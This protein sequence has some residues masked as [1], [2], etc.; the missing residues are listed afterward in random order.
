MAEFKFVGDSTSTCS[1][2]ILQPPQDHTLVEAKA[3]WKVSGLVLRTGIPSSLDNTCGTSDVT[4]NY[5]VI[6]NFL[7]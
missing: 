2:E 1:D 5:L 6:V 7:S 4:V 3:I